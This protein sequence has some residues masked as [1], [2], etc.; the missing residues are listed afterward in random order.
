MMFECVAGLFFVAVIRSCDE[1]A[2][3]VFCREHFMVVG[4]NVDLLTEFLLITVLECEPLFGKN[5]CSGNDFNSV[6][7]QMGV[8][9]QRSAIAAANDAETDFFHGAVFLFERKY[10]FAVKILVFL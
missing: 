4:V 5:I 2:V 9:S 3:E 7:G 1:N 10:M 6:G 8:V